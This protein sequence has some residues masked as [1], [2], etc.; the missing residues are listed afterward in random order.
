[1]AREST[2]TFEQVAAVA[3]SIKAHGGKATMRNVRESLGSG[4]MAT[5]LK[6]LQQWQGGQLRQSQ[7][8]DDAMDPS[9]ARAISN[10]IASKVQEA[11]ANTTAQL[12]DL[13]IETDTLIAENER[14][15]ADIDLQATELS[16]LQEQYAALAGRTQQLET[17]ATR[18][19]AAL[20]TERQAAES[21]RVELAKA[22]LRLEAVPR[23]EAEI[24]KVR[25]ELLEARAQSAKLHEEAAVATAKLESEFNLRQ[26]ISTQLTEATANAAEAVK[27]A[28]A[29]A[30]ALSHENVSVQTHQARLEDAARELATA[31]ETVNTVRAEAKKAGEEAAELRGQLIAVSKPLVKKSA[32]TKV[33]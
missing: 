6:F 19:A 11:T 21:A 24:E 1:M 10:Q 29:N 17:E 2:I 8:I 16:A 15:A 14:Q 5:I 30:E 3:G 33:E 9:I 26:S 4:S 22:E 23:I 31:N 32:K 27:R 12:A 20:V 7:A 28:I 13:Q 25:A 18:T